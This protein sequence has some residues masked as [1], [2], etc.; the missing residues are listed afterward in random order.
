MFG[1]LVHLRM[2]KNLE[3]FLECFEGF[4]EKRFPEHF[5]YHIFKI[6]NE[7]FNTKKGEE[8]DFQLLI[9]DEFSIHYVNLAF[10]SKQR[11][12]QNLN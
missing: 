7:T 10:V 12:T 2:T 3:R 4:H 1:D 11:V 5:K 8:R 9:I 6:F